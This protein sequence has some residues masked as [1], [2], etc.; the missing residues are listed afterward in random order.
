MAE[1]SFCILIS[2]I[3]RRVALAD[4][5]RNDAT[6]LG[7]RPE[8]LGTDISDLAPGYWRTDRR[9]L[10]PRCT[11]PDFIDA[12]LEICRRHE[13]RLVIPT[14][15]TELA[16][17]AEAAARFEEIGTTVMVSSP[18]VVRI[19]SDK[20][21]T[22]RWL[23]EHGFP[24]PRQWTAE[25]ALATLQASDYPL[26][27]KPAAGSRSIGAR[28]VAHP[29]EL[30]AAIAD[31]QRYVVEELARGDEY[32]VSVFV[33]R[34][35]HCLCAVPRRRLEVRS[36]EVSKGETTMHRPLMDL[37]R[38][39]VEALPGAY[40]ALNVQIFHDP[41]TDT[42]RVIEINPRFGGGYPL[43]WTAGA[44]FP[45]WLLEEM[46]DRT[47]TATF[48]GWREGVIMLRY[49]EEVFVQRRA[50]NLPPEPV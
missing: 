31:G 47:S 25:Q 19:A 42:V 7:L 27:V 48:D 10:V 35:G 3:G 29:G 16:P 37:A 34:A 41:T 21:H 24:A 26:F 43:A 38:R 1:E 12:M 49:D 46:L 14:I 28:R 44:R 45:R 30:R 33:D 18:E 36:G 11:A 6:S 22:H 50:P 23:A 17:L 32:T 40:G 2:S 13:V 5:V 15:D 4:C 9:E 20:V 39:V 8:I